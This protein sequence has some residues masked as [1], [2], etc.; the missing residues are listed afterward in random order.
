MDKKVVIY[1]RTHNYRLDKFGEDQLQDKIKITQ[2][3]VTDDFNAF[4]YVY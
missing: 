4:Q 3:D 2:F 1:S